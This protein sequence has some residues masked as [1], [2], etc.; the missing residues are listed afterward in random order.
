MSR[1]THQRLTALV[2]GGNRGIGLEVS[3]LM[4]REGLRVLLTARDV[5]GGEGA[6]A[7]LRGEG[8]EVQ[9]VAM[10]VGSRASVEDCASR[11]QQEGIHVDVLINNA[12][13]L[14][15]TNVLD[16]PG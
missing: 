7:A 11:L 2:T 15:D 13:I 5:E 16:T 8:L 9:F 14:G 12:A 6:A 1:R 4:A 3:R 10:D